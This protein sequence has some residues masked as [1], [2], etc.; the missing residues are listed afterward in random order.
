MSGSQTNLARD[1]LL[2]LT[3]R[4][5]AL[6]ERLTSA[7]REAIRTGRVQLASAL[8]PSRVLAADLGVSRWT[9]TQAYTQLATEGYLEARTGSATRVRWRPD[10]AAWE[11]FPAQPR[12]AAPARFDMTP[13]RPDLRGFPVTRWVEA[14]RIAAATAS[15]DQLGYPEPE[16]S[17]RLREVLA[18]YLNRA[19]GSAVRA[20]QVTVCLRAADAMTRVCRALAAD[21]V[22]QLAVEDPG[23]PPLRESASATGLVIVPVPVDSDGLLVARLQAHPKVKAVCV[24]ASHQFPTGA[25]LSPD[26]RAELLEWARR[27]DGLIIEDDYDAEFRYD[28]PAVSTLQGMAPDRVFLLGSV[29]KTLAPAVGIGWVASPPRLT[30][31]I[32]AA[33]PFPLAPA[34][35]HQLALAWFIESGSYDRHLR[36][37][38][39]RYQGRRQLL[40]DALARQLP[41]YPIEGAAAGLH[42]VLRLPAGTETS[43]VT[44]GAARHGLLVADLDRFRI[45]PDTRHPGL[46]LGYGNLADSAV[47]AA[48]SVLA[49]TLSHLF[50]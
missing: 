7:L 36:A 25:V 35:L 33:T 24:G 20:S 40:L 14:I 38:R 31:M 18:E 8:P 34:T 39:K 4:P 49:A 5:G 19:R 22:T 45:Q 12:D 15:H 11:V 17:P 28:R 42:L 21:G 46:V 9:V 10:S 2:E 32:R 27:S 26:R 3:G 44:T 29:S 37:A 47:V 30:A 1:V 48:V 50:R 6:H 13:G 16:G 41:G 23:W 43:R